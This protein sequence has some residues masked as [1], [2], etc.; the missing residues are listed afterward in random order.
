[1]KPDIKIQMIEQHI[2]SSK[3]IE[4]KDALDKDYKY[5]IG[6][7]I[8][9]GV[10]SD[11]SI[12]ETAKIKGME[13]LPEDFEAVNIIAS[14]SVCPN[15][16]FFCLFNPIEIKGDDLTITF[17]DPKYAADYVLKIQVLL[18]ND[19]SDASELFFG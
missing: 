15:K 10:C 6:I 3:S 4:L 8:A 17:N 9:D 1:M 7:A 14:K 2:N 13:F 18:T 11:K 19:L 16:R 12:I 5:L